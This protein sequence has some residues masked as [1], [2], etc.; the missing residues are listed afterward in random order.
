[1]TVPIIDFASNLVKFLL[2]FRIYFSKPQF[3]HLA[4]YCEGLLVTD[5]R[6]YISTMHRQMVNAKDQSCMNRFITQAPW[7]EDI[8]NEA[9]IRE[10][11]HRIL[12]EAEQKG[13]KRLFFI[14]DNTVT[15][16]RRRN[17]QSVK[18][19]QRMEGVS[20][21]Y[22]TVH[23]DNIWSSNTVTTHLLVG[24]KDIPLYLASYR[25]KKECPKEAYKSEIELMV[26]QIE[27]FD[28]P[29]G[30]ESYFLTDA[31]YHCKQVKETCEKKGFKG[32][33][34]KIKYNRIVEKVEG[35]K[36]KE[37]PVQRLLIWL[38]NKK[39]HGFEKRTIKDAD[40]KK[41]KVWVRALRCKIQNYG[42][43]KIVLITPRLRLKPPK[44]KKEKVPGMYLAA[45]NLELSLD[46][47]LEF[48]SLRWT[49]ETFYQIV[50]ERYGWRDYKF[51]KLKSMARHWHLIFLVYTF[52]RL[53]AGRDQVR[54]E[55]LVI[56]V[57]FIRQKTLEGNSTDNIVQY[58]AAA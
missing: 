31:F 26:E 8:L 22:S 30:F 34:G 25:G 2:I 50:K 41:K 18:K 28:L 54:R 56:F 23:K 39:N 17:A 11:Y 43:A 38:S 52:E 19:R 21:N 7:N 36:L 45:S 32:I 42:D 10:S 12:P 57:E 15:K 46:E 58:L 16:K 5:G 55:N 47:I 49:I 51:L 33:A 53:E 37:I 6:K 4:R 27:K 48:V 9:R 3:E 13:I 1:M 24:D 44:S 14:G 35:F 20:R 29:A 40:G